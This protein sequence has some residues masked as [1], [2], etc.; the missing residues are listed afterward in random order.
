MKGT[1]D[2]KRL[3]Q[4]FLVKRLLDIMHKDMSNSAIIILRSASTANHLQYVR[5]RK[6]NV[7]LRFGV[8]EFSA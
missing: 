2:W 7:T 1:L 4:E 8:V 5:D 6:V 3:M